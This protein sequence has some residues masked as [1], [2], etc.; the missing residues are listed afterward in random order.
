MIAFYNPV[1]KRRRTQLAAAKEI[2]LEHRSA[3]TPV[4]LGVNLGRPEETIRV[5][6]LH[7]LSVDD[8]D[9]LTTVLVGSTNTRTVMRGDGKPFVYTPRGYAKR[10]DAP[11]PVE[12]A[13][14][15]TE[16]APSSLMEDVTTD[17]SDILETDDKS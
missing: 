5:T 12:A 7:A 3:A 16:A 6:S 8:V 15:A 11:K 13:P 14:V 10:I 2:L 4:I 9:M 1:S 17:I